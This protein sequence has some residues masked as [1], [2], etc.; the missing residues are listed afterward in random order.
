MT[1]LLDCLLFEM[2]SKVTDRQNRCSLQDIAEAYDHIR[3]TY[4]HNSGCFNFPCDHNIY[5]YQ[6]NT[7]DGLRTYL[8]RLD[9]GHGPLYPY[10]TFVQSW[11]VD[12]PADDDF[13]FLPPLRPREIQDFLHQYAVTI[14]H[15]YHDDIAALIEAVREQ[16][17]R[18]GGSGGGHHVLDNGMRGATKFS[19]VHNANKRIKFGQ[20]QADELATQRQRQQQQQQ[21]EAEK[22][23]QEQERKRQEEE[24][25]AYQEWLVEE[26][27]LRLVKEKRKQ[28][29]QLKLEEE[30]R[31]LRERLAWEQ[32][33]RERQ[34]MMEKERRRLSEQLNGER[35]KMQQLQDPEEFRKSAITR[36]ANKLVTQRARPDQKISVEKLRTNLEMTLQH[37]SGDNNVKVNIFGSFASGLCSITSDVDF[38]VYNFAR[39]YPDPI[40]ELA[41]ALRLAGYESVKAIA[42]ARVP[43]VSFKVWSFDC[44]I[45]LDQPMGVINSKL[46]GTYRKIDDRFPS[47]WFA[48]KHLAKKH[49]ILSGSTGFLS[50]YALTMML[51]V[52]LQHVT[53]PP[54]L[55][56]LQ[57]RER[58]Q[59]VICEID[60]H[61]FS[62]D[63]NWSNYQTFGGANTKSV[64]QLLLDFCEFYGCTFNYAIQEVNPCLGRI[65]ARSYN[66]PPRS[67][68]D[69]KPKDWPIC[70]LDPFITG[71]N[72]AD[73]CRSSNVANIQKCFRDAFNALKI[74]D[75]DKA[76]KRHD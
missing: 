50:S 59:M 10:Q 7:V 3:E 14:P 42:N 12:S 45:S 18:D 57:Q 27:R 36:Y 33:L 41:K 70:I 24:A 23:K 61:D 75:T 73:N 16:V 1:V 32:A 25:R 44:D 62:F 20:L 63:R 9:N 72:V 29:Q 65:K 19:K 37:H 47:L 46:I 71:R 17:W 35:Q 34:L 28:E 15:T 49:G 22:Q 5:L 30:A 11:Y 8:N 2:A 4:Q 31:R 64:G 76:F 13:I 26:Q 6:L 51:I 21:I 60:G 39:R 69:K 55:P 54:I 66:P 68:K 67:Q 38:T 74:G 48:I 58:R 43:I 53:S 56:C 40:A 52:F